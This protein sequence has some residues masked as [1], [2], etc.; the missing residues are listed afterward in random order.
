MGEGKR[1]ER[2]KGDWPVFLLLITQRHSDPAFCDIGIPIRGCCFKVLQK[3]RQATQGSLQMTTISGRRFSSLLFKQVPLK[4]KDH[5][6]DRTRLPTKTK[7]ERR[8]GSIQS[9]VGHTH[10]LNP[11]EANFYQMQIFFLL[12]LPLSITSDLSWQMNHLCTLC[13]R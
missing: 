7:K 3:T 6:H 8:Q 1:E 5:D 9:Q 10:P 13:G 2:W 12:G 11:L 4:Y